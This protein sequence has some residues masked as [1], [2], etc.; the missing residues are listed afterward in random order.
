LKKKIYTLGRNEIIRGFRSFE[1]ILSESTRFTSG[2]I[3]AF[4]KL[5]EGISDFPVK[6]GFLMSKKKL[7]NLTLG[8]V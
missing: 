4:V 5:N 1:S 7:K 2:N 6:V 8:T 3:A